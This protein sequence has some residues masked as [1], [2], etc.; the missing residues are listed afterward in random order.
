[1]SAYCADIPELLFLQ[2]FLKYIFLIYCEFQAQIQDAERRWEE[3][4]SY[5]RKRESDAEK[6]QQGNFFFSLFF[7]LFIFWSRFIKMGRTLDGKI[8]FCF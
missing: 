6:A 3:I 4:E 2:S 1:M 5:L 8:K 7:Y